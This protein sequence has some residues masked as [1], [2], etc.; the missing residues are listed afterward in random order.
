M[1]PR[2]RRLLC[3]CVYAQVRPPFFSDQRTRL[4]HR[5]HPHGCWYYGCG[6][7]PLYWRKLICWRPH[8]APWPAPAVSMRICSSSSAV[9]LRSAYETGAP[10]SSSW[11]LVLWLWLCASLLAE[12]DLLEA[13]C[14]PVAGACCVNAYMLKFVRRFSQISVRD[15]RTVFILMGVG[16]MVVVMRLFIGGS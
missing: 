12:A 1:R 6:Y 2:G 15:W 11:V 14:G 9:F 4:A 5:I 7:A 13:A 3:Q 10:Y 16:I 8:A